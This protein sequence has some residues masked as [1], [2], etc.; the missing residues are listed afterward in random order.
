LAIKAGVM[1]SLPDFFAVGELLMTLN[2]RP[3]TGHEE[4]SNFLESICQQQKKLT[5]ELNFI[6]DVKEGRYL[7]TDLQCLPF[8]PSL[9]PK[10]ASV[11][12]S[13]ALGSS[14]S[15]RAQ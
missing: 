1:P 12:W 6:D 10:Q 2:S 13:L 5:E 11:T 14:E 8:L 9:D 7:C 15:P 4:A 3:P